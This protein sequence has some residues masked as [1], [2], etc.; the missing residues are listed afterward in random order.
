MIL[1]NI[2][3]RLSLSKPK[4]TIQWIAACCLACLLLFPATSAWAQFERPEIEK[5]PK[6]RRDWFQ[7]QFDD[8]KWTGR[9]LYEKTELDDRQTNE[10]RARLQAQFG[11]PTQTIEDLIHQED[12]RLGKAIEFEYW[13]TVNDSIP[14]MVLDWDGPFGTGLT[15]VGASRYIDLMPQIK[16]SFTQELMGL[17]ELGTYQDYFYSPERQQWY[18]VK[19]QN[20]DY[21]TK[22]IPSPPGMT[23]DPN[24][25]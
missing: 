24:N 13:F 21:T 2:P 8:I 17:K 16:R 5:V 10:L 11:D 1:V 15:Y 19:Y 4:G 9:G 7:D 22:E 18:N 12:F 25:K 23:I 20:G 14:M 3:S 6:N